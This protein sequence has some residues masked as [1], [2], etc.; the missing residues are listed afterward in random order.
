[1]AELARLIV[2]GVAGVAIGA[3]A[4]RRLICCGTA[5]ACGVCRHGWTWNEPSAPAARPTR[6][7]FRHCAASTRHSPSLPG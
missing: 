4:M 1:M 5:S 6:R 3:V 2:A 7:S